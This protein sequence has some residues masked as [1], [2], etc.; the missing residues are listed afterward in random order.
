MPMGGLW[1]LAKQTHLQTL[2]DV[3]FL[4]QVLGHSIKPKSQ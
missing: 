3:H 1:A 4:G 2:A